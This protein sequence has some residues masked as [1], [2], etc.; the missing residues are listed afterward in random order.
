MSMSETLFR[1]ESVRQ[2]AMQGSFQGEMGR[3]DG[4]LQPVNLDELG[5]FFLMGTITYSPSLYLTCTFDKSMI[6]QLSKGGTCWFCIGYDY[7]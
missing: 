7:V 2:L 1:E 5:V 4:N 6:F 3:G